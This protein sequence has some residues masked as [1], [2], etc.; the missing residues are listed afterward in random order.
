ML[1]KK[2]KTHLS[3]IPHR[4]LSIDT[5]IYLRLL[6]NMPKCHMEIRYPFVSINI[7]IYIDRVSIIYADRLRGYNNG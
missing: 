5:D 2:K 4:I 7:Y 3:N 1:K 6:F